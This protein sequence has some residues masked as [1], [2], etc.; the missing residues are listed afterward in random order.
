MERA[1]NHISDDTG[2]IALLEVKTRIGGSEI[3]PANQ[4]KI[5]RY[6]YSNHLGSACLELNENAEVL[7]YEEFHPFGTSSYRSGNSAAEVKLRNYRY[8]GKERDEETGLYNYGARLYFAS[9]GRFISSD[10]LRDSYPYL[11]SY[12]YAGNKP[13]TYFDIDGMQSPDEEVIEMNHPDNPEIEKKEDKEVKLAGDLEIALEYSQKKGST[14][15]QGVEATSTV[16][17]VL[18]KVQKELPMKIRVPLMWFKE[19]IEIGQGAVGLA[20]TLQKVES[21]GDVSPADLV[22]SFGL[23]GAIA[24]YLVESQIDYLEEEDIESTY[25]EIFNY[26][27]LLS[28]EQRSRLLTNYVRQHNNELNQYS[29]LIIYGKGDLEGNEIKGYIPTLDLVST[30]QEANKKLGF[31]PDYVLIGRLKDNSLKEDFEGSIIFSPQFKINL[32]L[33]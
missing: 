13:I 30:K 17:S 25:S 33:K 7:S 10:L 19:Q 4:T 1:I 8:V 12:N 22:G 2:R 20:S 28:E 16:F 23:V 32:N 31:V 3:L 5:T 11:N 26:R 24:A 21:G 6:Q 15:E 14:F 18:F 29:A 9:I 27:G